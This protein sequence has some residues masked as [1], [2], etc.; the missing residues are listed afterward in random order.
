MA[1]RVNGWWRIR[2]GVKNEERVPG[3][4]GGVKGRVGMKEVWR[5]GWN[6][7]GKRVGRKAGSLVGVEDCRGG[8]GDGMAILD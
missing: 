2:R 5:E 7:H 1:G 3:R 8:E 4:T 6:G